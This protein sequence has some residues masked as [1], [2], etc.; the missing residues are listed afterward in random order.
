MPAAAKAL[1]ISCLMRTNIGFPRLDVILKGLDRLVDR[2]LGVGKDFRA[3]SPDSGAS[4][5]FSRKCAI[6]SLAAAIFLAL[7]LISS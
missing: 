2:G 5:R 1:P 7:L 4:R 6:L 3:F